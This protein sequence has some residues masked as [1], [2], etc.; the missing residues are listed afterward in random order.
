MGQVCPQRSFKSFGRFVGQAGVIPS[1]VYVHDRDVATIVA[2]AG[3]PGCSET[4]FF[5]IH[6]AQI[7]GA[8]VAGTQC[9]VDG[10]VLILFALGGDVPVFVLVVSR[11]FLNRPRFVPL[12][13]ADE[14]QYQRGNEQKTEDS[15]TQRGG[16]DVD[17]ILRG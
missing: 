3:T 1:L 8:L 15:G 9:L 17:A 6:P 2:A 4:P 11:G 5:P 10:E 16:Q 12:G 7:G 13:Q 14:H